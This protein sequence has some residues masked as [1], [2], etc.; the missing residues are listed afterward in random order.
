MY[1]KDISSLFIQPDDSIQQAIL[2]IDKNVCGIALVVDKQQHLLGTITDGDVR[3]A[4]L[5]GVDLNSAVAGLLERK[6][7][8]IYP[9]PIIAA[10]SAESESLLKLMHERS[11]RQVPLLDDHQ[12]VVDMVVLTDLLPLEDLPLQAVLMAGGFGTRL[13]PLTENIPKPLLPVGDR[14]LMELMIEQLR[15]SGIHNIHVTTHYLADK[16]KDYFGDGESL[17]VDLQYVTEDSPLGT[18]GAL[19]LITPG[20]DPL[21][22]LNGDILTRLN[23]RAMLEFHRSHKLS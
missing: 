16:V 17:G 3:R 23:F 2:C 22:V 13:R 7:N 14:P 18:A 6:K 20:D 5:A 11:I 12:R 9:Q 15:A 21:L 8:S 19:G 1:R 4:I 10:A